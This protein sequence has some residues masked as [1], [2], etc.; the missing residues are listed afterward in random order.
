MTNHDMMASALKPYRGKNLTTAD[1]R[2]IVGEAFP[3]FN[4]GSLLPNDH[5]EGNKSP[6]WCA[7]GNQRILDRV[8][9]GLYSVR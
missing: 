6:C 8:E 9:Q 7:G 1:I 2:I 3:N 5:A 4:M